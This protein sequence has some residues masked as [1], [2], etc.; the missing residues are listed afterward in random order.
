MTAGTV[1]RQI[2]DLGP[3]DHLCLPFADDT[4][5]REIATAFVTAGLTRRERVLYFTDRASTATVHSWLRSGPPRTALHTGQLRVLTAGESYLTTGRFDPDTMV[6][7]LAAETDRS[8]HDG[9]TGLRVTGEMGWAVRDVPGAD[10]LEDYERKVATVFAA[11]RSAALCQYDTRLF[12][13]AR[14]HTLTGCH[15][16]IAEMNALHHDALSRITPAYRHGGRVLR[17]TGTIDQS[18]APALGAV[19]T[20][21]TRRPGDLR[22]DLSELEFIDVAGLRVIADTA[23]RLTGDRRLHLLHLAPMLAGVIHLIGW[24]HEPRLTVTPRAAHP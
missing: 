15:H 14:L 19:L 18:N 9:Y 20:A 17:L 23:A 6:A 5:Q 11:G 4:E 24:D 16:G 13:P 3:G 21:E 2:R 1:V 8:L 10:A 7:T 12:A 22:L